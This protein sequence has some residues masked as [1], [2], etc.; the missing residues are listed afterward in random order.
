MNFK[1]IAG[2]SFKKIFFKD[3]DD[4]HYN[5]SLKYACS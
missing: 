1:K 3:F 2:T 5:N 4:S